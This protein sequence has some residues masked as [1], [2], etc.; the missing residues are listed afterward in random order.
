MCFIFYKNAIQVNSM[1]NLFL[2]FVCLLPV[3]LFAQS[4]E[5]FK[6]TGNIKSLPDNSIVYIAGNVEND[7]IA[8]TF[9][10]QGSFILVGKLENTC[11]LMWLFPALERRV[12]LVMGNE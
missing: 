9:V 1:R 4:D 12:F 7:T 6:I 10:K 8:K 2:L 5:G 11:G 3:S